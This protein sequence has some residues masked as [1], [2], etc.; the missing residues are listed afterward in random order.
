MKKKQQIKTQKQECRNCIFWKKVSGYKT[1][2][3][4]KGLCEFMNNR[5]HQIW[6]NEEPKIDKKNKSLM[7][8]SSSEIHGKIG[9][10]EINSTSKNLIHRHTW[11]WT[12]GLFY[13]ASFSCR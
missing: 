2:K 3:T 8:N 4:E 12:D 6:E 13:C 5:I 9:D 10:L 7:I 1:S 11:V